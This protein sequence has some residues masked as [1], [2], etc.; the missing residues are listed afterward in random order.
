MPDTVPVTL[1]VMGESVTEGTIVEWRRKPGEAVTEG[2]VLADVT[3]DKVDVEVPAPVTGVLVRVLVE[4]GASAAVGAVIGEIAAGATA[5]ADAGGASPAPAAPAEA[6]AP[7]P[8]PAARGR[9]RVT[10][11]AGNGAEPAPAGADRVEVTLPAMGESVTEGTVSRW[12]KQV[13]DPVSRDEPLV[14]VT[15]DKVD[16]EVPAPATGRLSEILAEAGASV[17]V[18]GVLGVVAAGAA[19]E[20][21][22][23]ASPPPPAE[24]SPSAPPPSPPAADG[25]AAGVVE[26][27]APPAAPTSPH[28]PDLAASPLARRAAAIQG[29]DLAAVRGSG[30]AGLVRGGDVTAAASTRSPAPAAAPALPEAPTAGAVPLRGPAAML[31]TVMEQ[32]RE[33]PTATSFRTI[34]V[35]SLDARR[36]ELRDALRTA[37]RLENISFTH[38]VGYAI[39][40]AAL[41]VPSMTTHFERTRDGAAW[42]VQPGVHLGI[43]V[44]TRRKDGSRFLVVPVIRDA[45]SRSFATFRDDYERLIARARSGSLGVDELRGASLVLTNPGGIGTVA[46]VPRLMPGQGTIVATGAIGYPAEVRGIDEA[47]L[48][49]FGMAK[50]MT[51][52]STYDHRVIQGAESGEFLGRIEALLGGADGFYTEVFTSLGLAPPAAQPPVPERTAAPSPGMAVSAPRAAPP[53]MELLAAVGAGMSLVK[54]HRTHGHLGADLDPLGGEHPSDPAMD[55]HTV[56][57]TPALMAAV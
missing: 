25:A 33:I 38:L 19:A 3:T 1:P 26:P 55:P 20:T 9:A 18:G 21:A 56:G 53:R 30:P 37:G 31:A 41:D 13:G 14:E 12:L 36:R 7:P 49:D 34:S 29:V 6:P 27:P 45:G 54:A 15:T 11:A 47:R 42:R 22:E 32:S 28:R 24:S 2:E 10:A 46:S 57:L 17:Q 48:R 4:A 50:V 44:D 52:T 51:L 40:R 16:V 5:P 39:V 35:E 8:K 23:P 43:A